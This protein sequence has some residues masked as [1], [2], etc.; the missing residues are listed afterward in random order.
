MTE[1]RATGREA[2]R[3]WLIA[4]RLFRRLRIA[5]L[6][7]VLGGV[8]GFIYLNQIGLPGFAKRRLQAEL[9]ARGLDIEFERV[10]LR[11]YRGIVAEKLTVAAPARMKGASL[12]I[13]EME[14]RLDPDAL[15]RRQ[16]KVPSIA[17][18]EGRLVWPVAVSNEPPRELVAA[19]ITT[20]LRFLPNE[21]WELEKF[22]GRLNDFPVTLGGAVTHASRLRARAAS[23]DPGVSTGRGASL[24]RRGLDEMD[25]I[26]FESQPELALDVR[27]DARDG[28]GFDARVKLAT[29]GVKSPWGSARGLH[30]EGWARRSYGTNSPVRA[31][32]T[33]R[34]AEFAAGPVRMG[35][36][37]LELHGYLTDHH[38]FGT[39]HASSVV[40]N[41]KSENVRSA[42][43]SA[44]AL[45]LVVSSLLKAHGASSEI[46]LN[47]EELKTTW[48]EAASGNAAVL[49]TVSPDFKSF[50][51]AMTDL[52]LRSPKSR[53][54]SADHAEIGVYR[55]YTGSATN[56]VMFKWADP[57]AWN[58][59]W[60]VQATNVTA[61]NLALANLHADGSWRQPQLEIK[62]LSTKL[63]DGRLDGSASLDTETR[64]LTA[65]ARHAS[66][67][68]WKLAP[69]VDPGT[70]RFLAQYQ[71]DTPP[72]V[73]VEAAV[74]LPAWTNKAPDWKADVLPT[75]TL[76][77][78]VAG[79]RGSY[80]TVP[81]TA[82]RTDV[83]LSN[84][85][86]HLPNLAV[87][88]PEGRAEFS[89]TE[90]LR[91]RDYRFRGHAAIDPRAVR[92]LLE[93]DGQRRVLDDLRFTVPPRI[94]GEVRGCWLA[95][96]R[97]GLDVR[98]AV[99]NFILRGEECGSFT[100]AV[101][102]TNEV[103]RV[104]DARITRGAGLATVP[105]GVVDLRA[106]RLF[107]TNVHSTL[108]P[109]PVARAIGPK[110]AQHLAPYRFGKPPVA[111][112]N[113]SLPLRDGETTDLHFEISGGPFAWQR[114]NL[115]DIRGGIH[116]VTNTL[117]LTNVTGR[118]YG[119]ELRGDA[120]FD[121]TRD[122]G[123]DFRFSMVTAGA[124]LRALV[125]D[126]ST[127]TNRLEGT[128]SGVL[129]VTSGRTE[130]FKSWQG[131]GSA[132][133]TNGLLWD[134]PL[135]GIFSPVLNAIVPG[136]G[137]SRAREATANFTITNSVVRTTDLEIRSPPARLHYDGTIDFESR[138]N[139]R[140]EAE[141]FRDAFLVGPL[142]SFITT[143][144][145]KVFEYKVT[146][147]LSRPEGEPTYVPKF[148][149]LPLRPF[150]TLKQLIPG[151]DDSS[152]PP[153]KKK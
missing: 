47:A 23:A 115:P 143:P 84:E 83:T 92:P 70:R 34:F 3:G 19:G 73:S 144:L 21:T 145:T 132:R 114:F 12:F 121:F 49:L 43:A 8:A 151:L 97:V 150:H 112:V 31:E 122:D 65:K 99:T 39:N 66:F 108:D 137:A 71:F 96:D 7:L 88:R 113:G 124:D 123:A 86:L 25:R 53:W 26:Q 85:V 142:L 78:N 55:H 102:F 110:T 95:R 133:L 27:A 135:V 80:R 35:Q 134:V 10:R 45:H 79:G 140:V 81:F 22:T 1:E 33:T 52:T 36:G 15:R 48:G 147:T 37:E 120:A 20:E 44:R 107:L 41:L 40:L 9:H 38:Q 14:I 54:A 152:K 89:Y 61:T 146:G 28:G 82:V 30:V 76:A 105:L 127:P 58:V 101:Q 60:T 141:L 50:A 98:V 131:F 13:A 125:A 72:R 46:S 57:A 119:G 100:A 130:D 93:D 16:I 75:L 56:P 91:T 2:K 42:D 69:L 68:F 6:L 29:S 149:L 128:L 32:A 116:W 11:W 139:A 64:R 126:V 62:S 51:G 90:V 118:F 111:R 106:Q 104:T 94:E 4:R 109:M 103:F 136:L 59:Q 17:V 129:S 148:L 5:C 117:V 24:L 67:D 77:G 153:P 63:Y 18:R 74:T 138:V 87:Q